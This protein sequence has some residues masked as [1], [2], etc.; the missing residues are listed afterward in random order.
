M[1][2]NYKE[3]LKD[4]LPPVLVRFITGLSYGWYGNYATWSEAL[5]KCDGYNSPEIL[6]K[7]RE[8]ALKVKNGEASF[9]R[10]SV[11]F[12]NNEYSFPLLAGLLW[13]TMLNKGKLNLLDFGGSLGSSYFQ[14]KNFLEGLSELNWC[15]VEQTSYVNAGKEEFADD[16]L[17]FFNSIDDCL[18]SFDIQLV[19]LSSVLQYIEKPYELL[20]EIISKKPGFILI[21][22]TPFINGAD[23]ITVQKV[24]PA[25][26]AGSYPCWFFN[27]EK[28]KSSIEKRYSLIAAF[29]SLD[30]ANIKS[31]FKGFLY[32][33]IKN[34]PT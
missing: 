20:E 2:E 27:E 18:D 14:N 16:K 10:D 33:K 34:D 8:S 6:S 5:K 9:E 1:K 29:D 13:I 26:Y 28:F 15:V 22:R 32:R 31:S 17:H 3:I 23:R 24:N 11:L 30:K 25:I 19:L 4:I 12:N 7:V 21:D